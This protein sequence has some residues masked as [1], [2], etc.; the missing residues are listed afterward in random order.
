MT[1]LKLSLVLSAC[2]LAAAAWPA[3]ARADGAPRVPLLPAYV[4]EC[5]ACHVPFAPGLLPAASWQRLMAGLGRHY[6]SDASLDAATARTLA[7]WLQANAGSG[8]RAAEPPKDDRIT[9]AAWFQREHRELQSR[10]G[11][12]A[13][14]RASDCAACHT[15]AAEGSFSERE[16]RI[17]R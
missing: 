16:I 8:R 7:D 15:R 10:F 17:P 4:Q 2:V 12:A 9:Q 5:G 3:A 6:G 13:V 1:K 14:K 11:S